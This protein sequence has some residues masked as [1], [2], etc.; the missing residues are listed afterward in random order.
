MSSSRVETTGADVGLTPCLLAA[1]DA[2]ERCADGWVERIAEGRAAAGVRRCRAL[3]RG[4]AQAVEELA[5]AHRVD[6]AALGDV[7]EHRVVRDDRD[8]ARLGAGT[9]VR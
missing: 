3:G 2:F 1:A 8:S 5:G 6:A 9:V 7:A 4:G